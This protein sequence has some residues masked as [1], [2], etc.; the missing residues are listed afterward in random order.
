MIVL[1]I[2]LD[3]GVPCSRG[4]SHVAFLKKKSGE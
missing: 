3:L 2:T 4:L 1:V